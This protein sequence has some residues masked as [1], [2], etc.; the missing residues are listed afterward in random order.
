[1]KKL[2]RKQPGKHWKIRQEGQENEAYC[3]NILYTQIN[4]QKEKNN[5]V[6]QYGK[7]QTL[8]KIFQN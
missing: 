1:M 8:A 4:F 6:K 3:K 5:R 7:K 2:S